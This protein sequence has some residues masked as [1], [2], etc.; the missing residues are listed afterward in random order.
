MNGVRG[1]T[2][3]S[4]AMSCSAFVAISPDVNTQSPAFTAGDQGAFSGAPG[5]QTACAASTYSSHD[6]VHSARR[7]AEGKTRRDATRLLK[8]Y[9]ARHLYRILNNQAPLM[10]G[11]GFSFPSFVIR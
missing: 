10:T 5:G 9:L 3:A 4:A 7:I 2:R 11:A 6:S 8:R 1:S